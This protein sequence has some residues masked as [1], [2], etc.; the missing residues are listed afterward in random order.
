VSSACALTIPARVTVR[1]CPPNVIDTWSA[2]L[3]SSSCAN[4]LWW[5]EVDA[6]TDSERRAPQRVNGDN[7]VKR[8]VPIL[9]FGLTLAAAPAHE[10]FA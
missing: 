9:A 8:L 2:S 7:V 5:T 3:A 6:V 4:A 10:I 1:V